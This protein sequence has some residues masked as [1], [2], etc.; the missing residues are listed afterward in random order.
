MARCLD[1]DHWGVAATLIKQWWTKA[2][3]KRK[4][5]VKE[6]VK[7]LELSFGD[8]L[9]FRDKVELLVSSSPAVSSNVNPTVVTAEFKTLREQ[10]ESLREQLERNKS[11]IIEVQTIDPI[12]E[13]TLKLTVE[14]LTKRVDTL[15]NQSL[16]KWDIAVIVFQVLG[17]LGGLVGLIFVIR[18]YLM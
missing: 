9:E 15:E 7:D 13:A 11:E 5:Q 12:L 3:A 18:N 10:L 8:Q 16:S 4:T 17:A 1:P 14:N 6:R 2:K